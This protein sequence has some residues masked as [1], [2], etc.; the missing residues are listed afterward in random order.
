MKAQGERAIAG[1]G[2]ARCKSTTILCSPILFVTTV[3]T[4][5]AR[6]CGALHEGLKRKNEAKKKLIT[7]TAVAAVALNED[8]FSRS[9]DE[10]SRQS[11]R[12]QCD[13]Y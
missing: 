6:T 1:R 9:S 11:D 8:R 2:S 3:M 12:E 7:V 10:G 5:N 4:T 13:A